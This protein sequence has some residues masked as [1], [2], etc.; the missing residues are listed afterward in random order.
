MMGRKFPALLLFIGALSFAIALF[1][2]NL[3]SYIYVEFLIL[4]STVVLALATW[5]YFFGY[6]KGHIFHFFQIVVYAAFG[7]TALL[8]SFRIIHLNNTFAIMTVF[9]VPL[10]LAAII[11]Y[12]QINDDFRNGIKRNYFKRGGF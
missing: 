3:S 10:I 12:K 1:H 5:S 4:Y 11:N 9:F 7:L 2:G 8:Y 6:Q